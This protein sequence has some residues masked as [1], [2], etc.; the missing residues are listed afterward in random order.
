LHPIERPD[1]APDSVRQE[2]IR[3]SGAAVARRKGKAERDL[4]AVDVVLIDAI[5]AERVKSARLVV[6]G[7]LL[8]SGRIPAVPLNVNALRFFSIMPAVRTIA[9]SLVTP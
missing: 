4:D 9:K 1:V 3:K 8:P 6:P 5:D 7:R 2:E